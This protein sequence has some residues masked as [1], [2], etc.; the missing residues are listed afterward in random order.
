MQSHTKLTLSL[1]Q[2]NYLAYWKVNSW[3]ILFPNALKF[4]NGVF[5]LVTSFLIVVSSESLIDLFK[6]FSAL[7]LISNVDNICFKLSKQELFG[8]KAA[9]ETENVE[10]VVLRRYRLKNGQISSQS[11]IY[12]AM[13]LILYSLWGFF[14]HM[15]LSG[16]FIWVCQICHDHF[17]P[18]LQHTETLLHVSLALQVIYFIEY[19]HNA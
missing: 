11:I 7:S 19:I 16:T 3:L 18:L 12:A 15:Q 17:I 1:L 10:Q 13:A 5:A 8:A 2:T 14:I 6:D 9:K 4:I